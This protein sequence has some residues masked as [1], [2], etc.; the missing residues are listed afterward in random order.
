MLE[1]VFDTG[2]RNVV[3]E[4]IAVRPPEKDPI[5]LE[6]SKPDGLPVRPCA[7]GPAAFTFDGFRR[8]RLELSDREAID[9]FRTA[10]ACDGLYVDAVVAGTGEHAPKMSLI[11]VNELAGRHEER[12]VLVNL[13]RSPLKV[14]PVTERMSVCLSDADE[15]RARM[16]TVIKSALLD[17]QCDKLVSAESVAGFLTDALIKNGAWMDVAYPSLDR[18][19]HAH[20]FPPYAPERYSK[21]YGIGFF[22]TRTPCSIRTLVDGILADGSCPKGDV[23]IETSS[24]TNISLSYDAGRIVKTSGSLDRIGYAFVDQDR[25]SIREDETGTHW[26][27]KLA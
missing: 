5:R 11:A 27:V 20:D 19:A 12:T 26:T 16:R 1:L 17:R 15:V 4:H 18:S 23:T 22:L 10:A 25:V 24:G 6:F 7:G 9:L 14:R 13:T 21:P 2:G 8:G 3:L